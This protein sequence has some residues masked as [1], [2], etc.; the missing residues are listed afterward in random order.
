LAIETGSNISVNSDSTRKEPPR[1]FR[2][3]LL[4]FQQLRNK[5]IRALC[6][7]LLSERGEASQTVLAQE[8]I[9]TYE[10]L[11]DEQRLEFFEILGR[12][13]GTNEAVLCGLAG[14]YQQSPSVATYQ[15]LAA[16]M[17]SPRQKLFLRMN[18]APHGM[19]TLVTMRAH[20]GRL[21]RKHPELGP[22]DADLKYLFGLWFNRGFLRLERI[23]WH[24][25]ALILEK[26]IEYESVHEINGWPDL[27]RRLAPDRRCFAFF[28][29]ALIDEPIIFVEIALTKGLVGELDPLLD[30]NAPVLAPEE[31]DTATFYS[32]SNCLNGLRGISFGNFLIKQVVVELGNEL[33]GLKLYTTLSPLPRFASALRDNSNAEGFTRERLS[34]LLGEYAAKL[35]EEAKKPDPVDALYHLLEDPLSHRDVLARPLHRLALAYLTQSR[36]KGHLVD[37]VARFHLSNGARLERINRFGNARAYGLSDSFGLMAN[38]RYV[39]EEF[40]E[41]HE[42][43]V[44]EGRISVSKQLLQ[45]YR[46][47]AGLWSEP[48]PGKARATIARNSRE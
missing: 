20:V 16:A 23:G 45:E 18:T 38:Y 5:D 43:F 41:N 35:V 47:V 25:S 36:V 44:C 13:F 29:P 22:L 12:E 39:P 15:A 11:N 27:R 19:E 6:T 1:F 28:H 17:E 34:R 3:L 4:K 42:G 10:T 31:A 37:P 8:L 24:T 40:E 33:P 46:T 21:L 14:D 2:R 48:K 30:L 32:I 7:Q 26:L 9:S